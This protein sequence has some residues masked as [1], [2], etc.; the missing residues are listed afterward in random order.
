LSSS[1]EASSGL[2]YQIKDK[3]SGKLAKNKKRINEPG[4]QGLALI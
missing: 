2:S 4:R 1:A 3:F